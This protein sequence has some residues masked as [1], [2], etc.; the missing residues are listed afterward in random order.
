VAGDLVREEYAKN[1]KTS[2]KDPEN[3]IVEVSSN[4]VSEHQSFFLAWLHG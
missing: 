4:Q 3:N 1:Y 2:D